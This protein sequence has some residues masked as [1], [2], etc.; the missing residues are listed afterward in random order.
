[1][2][3]IIRFW[4][5]LSVKLPCPLQVL[6]HFESIDVENVALLRM[7]QQVVREQATKLSLRQPLVEAT[8]RLVLHVFKSYKQ[9]ETYNIQRFSA[10]N[11]LS[12]RE[13]VFR[14]ARQMGT[15]SLRLFIGQ[16]E[17]V[18]SN[19]DMQ[20][21]IMMFAP[22][23][24]E[25]KTVPRNVVAIILQFYGCKMPH[26]ESAC[27]LLSLFTPGDTNYQQAV[28]KI[29]TNL[30]HFH[31]NAIFELAKRQQQLNVGSSGKSSALMDETTFSIVEHALENI[32]VTSESTNA[33]TLEHIAWMYRCCGGGGNK[34]KDVAKSALFT[35][36]I[37]ML[38]E[39][40]C[41]SPDVLLVMLE[42]IDKVPGMTRHIVTLGTTL[43]SAYH[44]YFDRRFSECSHATYANVIGEMQ[45]AR[46]QCRQYVKDGDTQFCDIV[47]TAVRSSH[48][49]K[50]KLQKMLGKE[51]PTS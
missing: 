18:F 38:C 36:M 23:I 30:H 48:A 49:G 37:R 47:V 45:R 2:P 16:W 5:L 39:N 43:L 8:L 33:K 12:D 10:E 13:F 40:A 46:L 44:H 20:E 17:E 26:N 19:D 21:L 32:L 34:P 11:R 50:K 35:R 42:C 31:P 6:N 14:L 29:R 3:A 27:D 9:T 7:I 22:Q 25:Y 28:A 51:F 15:S 41:Y 24:R 4:G 1:M